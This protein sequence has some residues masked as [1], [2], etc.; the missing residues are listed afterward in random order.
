M[1]VLTGGGIA[2]KVFAQ[3]IKDSAFYSVMWASNRR[4]RW[5]VWAELAAEIG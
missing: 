4:L 1:T 3:M 5:G 2:G